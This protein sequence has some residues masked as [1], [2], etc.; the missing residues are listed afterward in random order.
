MSN[1]LPFVKLSEEDGQGRD[2]LPAHFTHS[3]ALSLARSL[4]ISRHLERE[5]ISGNWFAVCGVSAS[6]D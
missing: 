3:L 6:S 4:M 2:E 5:V 1:N